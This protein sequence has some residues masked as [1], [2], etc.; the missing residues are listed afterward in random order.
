M[1]PMKYLTGPAS[2][3]P[4][5]HLTIIHERLH[6]CVGWADEPSIPRIEDSEAEMTKAQENRFNRILKARR[7]ELLREIG[8]RRER[9]AIDPASD[10]MDQVR[11][12]ADR[13]LAIRNSDRM[14]SVLRSVERALC[15]IRDGTYGV[16]AQCS[17]EIP[18]KRLEAVPWTR[19]C[20]AC[21]ERAELCEREEEQ[22]AETPYALAG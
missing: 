19:Y 9:L 18:S 17:D 5:S 16:C 1:L 13:D 2:A 21:Q 14:Y 6:P 8:E 11:S 15:D 22:A 3:G 4:P 12:I 7:E 20:V 10:P